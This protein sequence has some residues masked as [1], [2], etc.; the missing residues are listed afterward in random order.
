MNGN[1]ESTDVETKL[2]ELFDRASIEIEPSE[3]LTSTIVELGEP[4]G[5]KK[6]VHRLQP[7]SGASRKNRIATTL[8]AVAAAAIVIVFI[9]S[10]LRM[11]D[12]VKADDPADSV[13]QT[14][15]LEELAE[16][17]IGQ[18]DDCIEEQGFD[19]DNPPVRDRYVD[20]DDPEIARY[21]SALRTADGCMQQ[22]YDF[23]SDEWKEYRGLEEPQDPEILPRTPSRT[24]Y[25]TRWAEKRPEFIRLA[26]IDIAMATVED[27][28]L[29]EF[30]YKPYPHM[31]PL[32]DLGEIW[33]DEW[34]GGDTCGV[35]PYR[36]QI[37]GSY[38][39]IADPSIINPETGIPEDWPRR[40]EDGLLVVKIKWVEQDLVHVTGYNTDT[41]VEYKR[42]DKI[43]ECP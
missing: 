25:A 23:R 39:E 28:S 15:S 33:I 13:H 16:R 29:D 30:E 37:D 12:T 32:D 38:W 9:G 7:T 20:T 8:I 11:D 35:S 36:N 43:V 17:Y 2:S 42:T 14:E 22:L 21:H 3:K 34:N 6:A 5:H 26:A 24:E 31:E 40:S 41:P 10:R 18:L 19:P 4:E 1:T 27:R